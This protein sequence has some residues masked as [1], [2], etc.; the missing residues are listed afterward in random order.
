MNF[1]QILMW[2]AGLATTGM[3]FFSVYQNYQ[4]VTSVNS[5]VSSVSRDTTFIILT[6]PPKNFERVKSF[7]E[8]HVIDLDH[9]DTLDVAFRRVKA[10]VKQPLF[11]LNTNNEQDTSFLVMQV[12]TSFKMIGDTEGILIGSHLDTA[13]IEKI[14][15]KISSNDALVINNQS[16]SV[17][18]GLNAYGDCFINPKDDSQVQLIFYTV[19]SSPSVKAPYMTYLLPDGNIV[20][21]RSRRYYAEDIPRELPMEIAGETLIDIHV[22]DVDCSVLSAYEYDG[23]DDEKVGFSAT[24]MQL[25]Q[26]G[27]VWSKR[28]PLPT[29]LPYI[30]PEEVMVMK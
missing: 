3:S 14:N 13:M 5:L 25:V 17:C 8:T 22:F 23:E 20:D 1:K 6:H 24:Q 12:D 4:D 29:L 21:S 19:P 2:V 15:L 26:P 7:V 28:L 27:M 18:E 16:C 11:P 10:Q 30:A 9:P